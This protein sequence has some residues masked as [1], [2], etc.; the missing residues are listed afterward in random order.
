MASIVKN[1]GAWRVQLYVN[2]QRDSGT[3]PTKAQAQAWASQRETELRR[4]KSTGIVVGKTCRDAFERY[5]QEVSRSKRGY[6]WEALRLAAMADVKLDEIKFGDMKL[7]ELAAADIARW[8]DTRLKTVAGSTVNR[9]MNLLSHVLSTAR[10]EWGWIAESPTKDVRR[11]KDPPPRDRRIS[12][13]EIKRVCVSLGFADGPVC[14]KNQAVAVAFLFAIE[15]GMRAGEICALMPNDVS[16]RVAHLRRTKNGTKR[17]VPLS[18]R[19]AE[20]LEFLPEGEGPLFGLS[21]ASLD[22]LFRK[23]KERCMI[24]DMT[25]H[26]TRH[27]AITRLAKKLNV[28]DLARMVGHRDLRMLQVYYNETAAQIAARLD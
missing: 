16:E 23:A 17:D 25:F 1:G 9:E 15:T 24:T 6:R 13:D 3:F 10:R 7:S 20:L 5:E 11:P 22:A 12:K 28:L 14:T 27:E 18:A 26:D 19:A 21:A 4:Q 8:R 2:A